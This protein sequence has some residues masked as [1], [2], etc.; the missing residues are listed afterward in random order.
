[1]ND[2][3]LIVNLAF[4]LINLV[5]AVSLFI[6][7]RN[8]L[9]KSIDEKIRQYRKFNAIADKNGIVFL[10]DSLT[11]FYQVQE[12]FHNRHVYNRGIAS[13]TTEGV[14]RRLEENVIS[15]APRKVFLQIGTNDFHHRRAVDYIVTNIKRIIATLR[16]RLPEAEIYLI[17]LY[18]VNPKISFSGKMITFPRKN[19]KIDRI[20][21]LLSEYAGA[22]GITYI[23]IN[24]ALKND[25]GL[26][27][28]EYTIDGLHLT[29]EGYLLV[30]DILKKYIED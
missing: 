17:S 8:L 6:A 18:P 12:F 10:G 5:T 9:R 16:E 27:K 19:K 20:N 23:D 1:M 13:D 21:A 24:G 29:N 28:P 30:T 7:I 3:L 14:L 15:L 25:K 26:L 22:S 2:V 4:L 11:E